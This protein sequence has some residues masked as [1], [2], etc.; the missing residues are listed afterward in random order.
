MP[1]NISRNIIDDFKS[2]NYKTIV[3][4]KCTSRVIRMMPQLG[5]SLSDNSRSAI[6]DRPLVRQYKVRYH[7][8]LRSYSQILD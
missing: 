6:Y 3:I 8:W 2:I 7:G 1:V 4:M 5:E